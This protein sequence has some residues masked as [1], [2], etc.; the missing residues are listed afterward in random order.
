MKKSKKLLSIIL[1]FVMAV[2][3]LPLTAVSSTAAGTAYT[4]SDGEWMYTKNNDGTVTIASGGNTK[5]YLGNDSNVTVPADID[6]YMVTAIGVRAFTGNTKLLHVSIPETVTKVE[7][8]AFSGCSSLTSITVSANITSLGYGAFLNCT[9]LYSVTFE[10]VCT[11]GTNCFKGCTSLTRVDL[12]DGVTAIG[13]GA[14]ADCPA[15]KSILIP[16]SVTSINAAAFSGTTALEAIEGI[17]GSYAQT[18]ATANGYNFETASVASEAIAVNDEKHVSFDENGG[19]YF[20]FVPQSSGYYKLYSYNYNEA[21][22]DPYCEVCNKYGANVYGNFD[23][24]NGTRNFDTGSLYMEKDKVY[25]FYC[26]NYGQSVSQG[27]SYSVKLEDASGEVIS[28]LAI[29]FS[30][31]KDVFAGR[32]VTLSSSYTSG[33]KVDL[34]WSS[35]DSSI[36]KVTNAGRVYFY[37]AGSVKITLTD[38][39]SG[40]TDSIDFNVTQATAIALNEEKDV[41][42][43]NAGELHYFSFVPETDGYYSLYSFDNE[44]DCDPYC[45]IYK[46]SGNSMTTSDDSDLAGRPNFWLNY[47]LKAGVTYFYAVKSYANS[48]GSYK[49]KLIES[50]GPEQ[51]E[52]QDGTELTVYKSEKVALYVSCNSSESDQFIDFTTG[53]SNAVELAERGG[54]YYYYIFAKNVGTAT[55]TATAKGGASAAITVTVIDNPVMTVDTPTQVVFEAGDEYFY[56]KIDI[57]EAGI[58][59]FGYT[60]R[61]ENKSRLSATVYD[62]QGNSRISLSGEGYP[63]NFASLD[64][65]T[66]YVRVQYN[67]RIAVELGTY[68]FMCSKTTEQTGVTFKEGPTLNYALGL[69][70][71]PVVFPVPWSARLENYTLS[72]SDETV[73]SVVDGKKIQTN[74]PGSCTLTAT[75]ESGF[76]AVCTVVVEDLNYDEVPLNEVFSVNIENGGDIAYYKFS[77]AATGYYDFQSTG[78]LDTYAR[79]YNANMSNTITYNDDGDV[80][81][82]N[83]RIHYRLE[84]GMSYVLAFKLYSSD[85]TGEFNVIAT[86]Q[87]GDADV[88]DSITI[89]DYAMVHSYLAGVSPEFAETD[90]Y[91]FADW[92]YDGAVDAFDMYYLDRAMNS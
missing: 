11:M 66:Y 22:I 47:K 32:N 42:I 2:T 78:G 87:A 50:P 83:F 44:E 25:Y 21:N 36:A 34:V 80:E 60:E 69:V 49:I 55:I 35:S 27:S 28:S 54:D 17:T 59:K 57:A 63:N 58:Y 53:D 30:E 45:Y 75:S 46:A 77:P 89:D 16:D 90:G 4:S 9:G 24:V 37:A 73:A 26:T 91:Y 3:A 86:K 33:P 15:L 65:G 18:F 41:T 20:K 48:T 72:S 52:F 38:K 12:F 62:D 76:T 84:K 10:G 70:V 39:I 85:H 79:I 1:T 51:I 67:N 8:Y 61:S 31:S 14:F 88:N 74:K 29:R 64:P 5:A 81:G 56:Y 71:E 82:N 13:N 68:F 92:N 19:T 6:G 23:D 43:A 40:L 7:N